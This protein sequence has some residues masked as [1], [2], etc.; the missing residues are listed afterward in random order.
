MPLGN[1]TFLQSSPPVAPLVEEP[2]ALPV[3]AVVL[4]S[5]NE[6]A[7]TA[8]R[9]FARRLPGLAKSFRKQVPSERAGCWVSGV[10]LEDPRT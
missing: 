10:G 2:P 9:G 7:G 8:Q 1:P 4:R 3:V 6:D 5:D